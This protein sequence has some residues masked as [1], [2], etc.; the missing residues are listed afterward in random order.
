MSKAASKQ[1]KLRYICQ[2]C[3]ADFPKWGGKCS[4]CE[5][6]NSLEEQWVKPKAAVSNRLAESTWQ[7]ADQVELLR[8]QDIRLQSIHNARFW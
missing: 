2:S 5:A 8:L 1:P 6:W 3:G 7:H 4:A